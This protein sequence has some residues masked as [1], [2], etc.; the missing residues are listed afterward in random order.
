MEVCGDLQSSVQGHL[1][2]DIVDVALHSIGGEIEP[3]G[4]LLIAH[5]FRD[6]ENDLSFPF[7]HSDC[8]R[9][10]FPLVAHGLFDDVRKERFSQRRGRTR[11]PFATE[12][13]VLRISS[14]VA[15]L[16]TK[17][18]AP[19]STNSMTSRCDGMRPIPMT[20]ASGCSRASV[21]TMRSP[22]SFR[23]PRSIRTYGSHDELERHWRPPV[24][25]MVH[26]V[27]SLGSPGRN[28]VQMGV[29][30]AWAS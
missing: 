10:R 1:F 18:A 29:M 12:R 7:R 26:C 8:T 6:Q 4:D 23:N 13:I 15:S 17:P 16:R 3:L 28:R 2:E 27:P 22:F 20:L 19:A 14:I 5:P 24:G 9:Q 11:I 21:S 25:L 30:T